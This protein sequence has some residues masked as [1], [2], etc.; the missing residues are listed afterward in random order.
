MNDDFRDC[1]DGSDEPGTAACTLIQQE[2]LFYCSNEK[3]TPRW[4]PC[5]CSVFVS[6]VRSNR[7][8][9]MASQLPIKIEAYRVGSRG[10]TEQ[11]HRLNLCCGVWELTV[12]RQSVSLFGRATSA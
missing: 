9:G 6:Y 11:S 4:D 5:V 1:A 12:G 3:S 8:T 2:Q 7:A 10:H